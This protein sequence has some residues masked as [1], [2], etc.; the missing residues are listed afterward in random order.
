M[1]EKLTRSV[2]IRRKCLD[3]CGGS[4]SE[5]RQ[6]STTKCPLWKYRMG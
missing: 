5:V 3:C 1:E 4:K 6:C 2:A